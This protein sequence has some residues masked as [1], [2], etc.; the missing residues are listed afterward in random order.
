MTTLATSDIDTL[1]KHLEEM[2]PEAYATSANWTLILQ[3][4]PFVL[5]LT[6]KLGSRQEVVQ[7]LVEIRQSIHHEFTVSVEVLV[8]MRADLPEF[9][10]EAL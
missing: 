6:F 9:K 10:G 8:R 1:F 7:K 3:D 5:P 2:D 4:G